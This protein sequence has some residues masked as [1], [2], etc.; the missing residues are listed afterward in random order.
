M[1]RSS[2][3]EPVFHVARAPSIDELQ[4]L[5]NRIIQRVLKLLTRTGYLIEEQSMPY[6]AEAKSDCALTPLQAASCTYRRGAAG[7]Q[8]GFGAVARAKSF[9]ALGVA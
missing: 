8:R 9:A 7:A 2:E 3:G 6:L 1:Y 5:L 4:V